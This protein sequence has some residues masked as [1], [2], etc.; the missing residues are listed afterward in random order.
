MCRSPHVS[1]K[2]FAHNAEPDPIE[3]PGIDDH[4]IFVK[5]KS[6]SNQAETGNHQFGLFGIAESKNPPAAAIR[7]NGVQVAIDIEC[8]ALRP[9]KSGKEP[10]DFAAR[11]YAIDGVKARGRRPTDVEIIVESKSEVVCSDAGFE[12]GEHED[13]FTGTYFE[14]AA[15]AIADI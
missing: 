8:Q 5:I 4:Q 11:R 7:G 15:A 14:N 10:V 13:F 3:R 12:R 2:R 6:E 1:W 9:A